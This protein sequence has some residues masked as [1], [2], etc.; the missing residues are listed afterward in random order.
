MSPGISY[1]KFS[2][3]LLRSKITTHVTGDEDRKRSDISEHSH[4]VD[5]ADDGIDLRGDA[6][7][8]ACMSWLC[9]DARHTVSPLKGLHT[10]AL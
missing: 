10:T 6:D 3:R 8:S 7:L 1:S 2:I 9:L 4:S 5:R